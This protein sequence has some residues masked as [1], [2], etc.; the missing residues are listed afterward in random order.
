MPPTKMTI[1]TPTPVLR[2]RGRSGVLEAGAEYS[3]IS[4]HS[5][6]PGPLL[7]VEISIFGGAFNAH[8]GT[9]IVI[10][11]KTQISMKLK[12]SNCDENQ[13]LKL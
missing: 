2:S 7:G 10:E 1:K 3:S 12:N 8:R 4:S 13:K 6:D 9:Q 11:L 5:F